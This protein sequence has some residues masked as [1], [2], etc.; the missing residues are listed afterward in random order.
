MTRAWFLTLA[1]AIAI[2]VGVFAVA[3][4]QDFLASKGVVSNPA[5]DV[6]MREVGVVLTAIG[7]IAFWIRNEP[8]S[9]TMRAFLFGNLMLQLGLLPIELVAYRAGIIT[10]ALGVA[11]NSILHALLA[12]GFLYYGVSMRLR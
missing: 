5:A 7:V 12:A 10:E 3:L 8:S 6:W 11:P 4:P 1:S 9:P 2:A